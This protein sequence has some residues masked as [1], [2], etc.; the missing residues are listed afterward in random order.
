MEEEKSFWQ[1]YTVGPRHNKDECSY[2]TLLPGGREHRHYHAWT[3]VPDKLA[4][5]HICGV[6]KNRRDQ[7]APCLAHEVL[8]RFCRLYLDIEKKEDDEFPSP[9]LFDNLKVWLSTTAPEILA[10]LLRQGLLC[11]CKKDQTF[12][13]STPFSPENIFCW[14][15]TNENDSHPVYQF[16]CVL[17]SACGNFK[18]SYHVIWPFLIFDRHSSSAIKDAFLPSLRGE[19]IDSYFDFGAW[20]NRSLRSVF[21]DKI[22]DDNGYPE[23]RVL[24]PILLVDDS[25]KSIS[26]FPLRE[27]SDIYFWWAASSLRYLATQQKD[28]LIQTCAEEGR[29]ITAGEPSALV[30]LKEEIDEYIAID[31]SPAREKNRRDLFYLS[32]SNPCSI[33]TASDISSKLKELASMLEEDAL[34]SAS[35]K[36]DYLTNY[37]YYLVT[38]S[39]AAIR[40]K[41]GFFI[42]FSEMPG[43]RQVSVMRFKSSNP[44]LFPRVEFPNILI[45]DDSGPAQK[46]RRKKNLVLDLKKLIFNEPKMASFV[47]VSYLPP[48]IACSSD[49]LNLF[50]MPEISREQ[51]FAADSMGI[52]RGGHS[53]DLETFKNTIFRSLCN[54]DKVIYSYF[55]YWIA[56][57]LQHPGRK[58]ESA[59]FFSGSQGTGKN[60]VIEAIGTVFGMASYLMLSMRE[61]VARFNHSL[62]GKVLLFVN[63]S[64]AI[65]PDNIG[66]LNSLVTESTLRSEEKFENPVTAPNVCNLVITSNA[67][68]FNKITDGSARRWVM[69][70]TSDSYIG[71]PSFWKGLTDW[72]NVGCTHANDVGPS[73]LQIAKWLYSIVIPPEWFPQNIPFTASFDSA[74]ISSF[75]PAV[76][77]FYHSLC[78]GALLDTSITTI[79]DLSNWANSTINISTESLYASIISWYKRYTRAT[80][81]QIFSNQLAYAITNWV[82]GKLTQP[83]LFEGSLT[84]LPPLPICITNFRAKAPGISFSLNGTDPTTLQLQFPLLPI[85]E[86]P[87]IPPSE[88]SFH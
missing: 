33:I 9:F 13:S 87:D 76:N 58:N 56:N 28:T 57:I 84:I 41:Q 67:P 77:Y 21:C 69:I 82:G 8:P 63:E 34:T 1:G 27:I 48:G 80:E 11:F 43:H 60:V 35:Q 62:S 81:C 78:N 46:K 73:H 50:Q 61:L 66:L 5:D 54:G 72:I 20:N 6:W 40:E 26:D 16:A 44:L 4:R 70:N 14:W 31:S 29:N 45:E 49:T 83:P 75:P 10:R 22:N 7:R 64:S 18:S 88:S 51:A 23:H 79:G 71:H 59:I 15:N 36:I 42:S 12:N 74:R 30:K 86:G 37:A 38:K 19:E 85:P 68:I 25:G 17:L 32:K 3:T 55:V 24:T 47:A 53:F 2:Y 52:M 65:S 39:Y